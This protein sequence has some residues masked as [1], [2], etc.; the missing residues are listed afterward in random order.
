MN[1]KL[2]VRSWE[3]WGIIALSILNAWIGWQR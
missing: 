2:F 3:F 1:W